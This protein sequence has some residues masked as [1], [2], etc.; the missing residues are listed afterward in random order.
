MDLGKTFYT[1]KNI[2]TVIAGTFLLS[3]PFG[4]ANA[5]SSTKS[6]TTVRIS[7][8]EFHTTHKFAVE[9]VRAAYK[10]A[11]INAEFT[12]RP[13]R[14]SLI[15]ANAGR[16]DGEVARISGVTRKYKH[17][18][19]AESPTIN[20]EG[21]VITRSEKREITQWSDLEGLRI[22]IMRGELY[23]ERGTSAFEVTAASDYNQLLKMLVKNRIDVAIGIRKDYELAVNSPDF[24][25]EGLHIIG[26]PVFFAPLYHL[27]HKDHRDLLKKL[28]PVF[29]HMWNDGD[30]A[31]IHKNTMKL[32][33]KPHS[34]DS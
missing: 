2:L 8:C 4:Q 33:T 13:C 29:E 18:V 12:S 23:A 16:F 28:N 9:S 14:R 1:C 6:D 22:G 24:L 25:N 21:V 15:E 26:K 7:Y 20:I 3:L 32:L 11:G 17:L 31:K 19:A 34:P 10:R 30:T 5:G 27:V